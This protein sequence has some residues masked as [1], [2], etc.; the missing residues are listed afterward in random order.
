MEKVS[1][2]FK[3]IQTLICKPNSLL[4]V[5][6]TDD[7]Y[8]KK[9]SNKFSSFSNGFPVVD[10][11]DLFPD[12]N[13]TIHHGFL[14][15]TS[16]PLD[17]VL[18]KKCAQRF[19]DCVFLEIGTW[20]GESVANVSPF[21]KECFTL[22]LSAEEMR[23]MDLPEDRIASL[24]FFSKDFKNV[25]HIKANSHSFDFNSLGKKFDL[26]YI[27]GYHKYEDV[28]KDTEVLLP[29]LKDE[30]SIMIWHDAVFTS[31]EMR[32]EVMAAILD[33]VPK[34][35]QKHLYYVSNTLCAIY[36]PEQLRTESF[37]LYGKPS[38]VFEVNIRAKT[39]NNRQ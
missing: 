30:K 2:F 4:R 23:A 3:I 25:K 9:V 21:A 24:D 1:K 7:I 15:G 10:I 37:N 5:L 28:K 34:E 32:W 13:E 22:N 8:R 31:G 33:S 19:T 26:I 35:K 11:V 29:F 17:M 36:I 20:R 18:L 38:K 6:N 39:I 16:F 27:D 14:E 12:L